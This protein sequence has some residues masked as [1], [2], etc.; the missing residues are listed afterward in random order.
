M[1]MRMN[2]NHSGLKALTALLFF[3]GLSLFASTGFA[4]VMV[5]P[6]AVS[7]AT[8]TA[9]FAAINAGTHTGTVTVSITADTNEGTGTAI[10][11]ASGT[12]AASY[13]SLSIT[14]SGARTITGAT[15]AGNPMIDFNGAD[16]VSIDGLNTGGNSLTISNT[17]ASATSGTSTI[18]FIGGATSNTI[19]N[20]SILGSATMVVGTNGGNITSRPT[21]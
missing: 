19:T 11:N 16:N 17:A 10:L 1:L 3:L 20:A 7:Y 4:Q 15:T 8:L 12:G 14:P 2:T 18:R 9:A 21:P 5:N 6:G 13:T